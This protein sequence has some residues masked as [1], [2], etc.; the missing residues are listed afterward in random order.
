MIDVRTILFLGLPGSGKGTQAKLLAGHLGWRLFSSGDHFKGLIGQGGE[1]GER[2]AKDYRRGQLSPDWLAAYFFE[3]EIVH[4][5]SHTG[6]VCEGFAR[7]LPQAELAD[8]IF[9][10]MGR[11]YRVLYLAVNEE[12]ALRRQL[13]RSKVEN[14]PDSDGEGKIRG[15]FE[16]Y[17]AHTEPVLEFFKKKDAL[18][19]LNGEQTPEAIAADIRRALAVP[20]RS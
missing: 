19:E 13:A 4:L 16:V 17:H 2:I 10:W 18:I 6:I 11:P 7:S 12:E 1:L 20:D 14:R 8:E 3:D 5:A 9:T 15:R